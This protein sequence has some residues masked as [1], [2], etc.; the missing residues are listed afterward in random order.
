MTMTMTPAD[1]D[2]PAVV[3][4]RLALVAA[5]HAAELAPASD[6]ARAQLTDAHTADA[7]IRV[8]NVGAIATEDPQHRAAL[9]ASPSGAIALREPAVATGPRGVAFLFPGL[10]DHYLAMGHELYRGLTVFRDAVDECCAR[11]VPELGVDLR[12]VIYSTPATA[13]TAG[14]DLRRMLGRGGNGPTPA[15]ARLNQ[16]RHAQPALFVIEYALAMQWQ[17]WGLRPQIMLG[18]SLGEYVAACLSGVLSLADSLTL[19]ARRAEL[20]ET[21]PPGAMLAVL[22]PEAEVTPLVGDDLSLSAVSSPEM[23]VVAGPPEAVARF[24]HAQRADGVAVRR[25]ASV[26][27]FHSK[28]MQPIAGKVAELVAGFTLHPPRIPYISNVTG[29]PITGAQATDPAYWAA[30]L[31]QPVRFVDGLRAVTADIVLEVGPGKTLSSLATAAQLPGTQVLASMRHTYDP[32]PDTAVLLEAMGQLWVHGADVDW[33]RFPHAPLELTGA[34]A[35]PGDAADEA[36]R[37]PTSKTEREL[38]QLWQT[39][40]RCPPPS[41]DAN[42][43]DLGGNSLVATRL[44]DRVARSLRVKLPL[45]RIYET[46]S[47]GAMAEAIDRLRGGTPAAAPAA[48]PTVA[49]RPAATASAIAATADRR[50]FELPNGMTIAHQNEAETRHFYDD[51]FAHRSYV[52]HGITIPPAGIVLDVGGNIGMFTLFVHREQPSAR[53]LAFEPAPALFAI[54]GHNAAHHGVRATLF[55]Y[56]LSSC[57]QDAP[58]TFYPHSA[59]MS[60]FHPDVDEEKRNLRAIVA[61]QRRHSVGD[62]GAVTDYTDELLDVRFA[63]T[64]FTA[65][66]RRVSDVLREQNIERVDLMKVDVQKCELEVIQGIDDADWPRFAQIVLEAHDVDGRVALLASIFEQRGFTVVAEQDELY[67]GTNIYNLYATRKER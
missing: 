61:N 26:H 39:L 17:A 13:R 29:A 55:N 41:L 14:L 25:V 58:F 52:K 48:R 60:S 10:G 18:Y 19:V 28:M 45:R 12:E 67:A 37:Q 57:E 66:L 35:A 32:D 49:A 38:A 62:A 16:T 5:S 40:L 6:L 34:S 9:L 3:A 1:L 30:H 42:F 36:P 15:E 4:P 43:F 54:L 22:R 31:C 53:V 8:R 56:G 23:C 63:A 64:T 2:A 44:I 33:T 21:L 47:L 11:L 51:I 27:A 20:I 46:A 59:G 7:L 65:R 50:S 24:E